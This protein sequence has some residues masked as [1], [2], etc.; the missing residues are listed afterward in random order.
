M[1][2]KQ[3]GIQSKALHWYPGHMAKTKRLIEENLKLID[4]VVEITD[5][6]IPYSGRNPYFNVMLRNKPRLIVM[7]KADMADKSVTDKW[8]SYFSEKGIKVIPISCLTGMG[9]NKI[10]SEAE[11]LVADKLKKDAENG[12]SRTLKLMMIGIPNVGKSSLIN[13]LSG[14]AGTI[15]GNKPG[16][17]KGKQWIRLK[18][19]SELLDTP[20]ILPQKFSDDIAPK[21]LAMTGAIKDEI[22]NTEL[23]SYDLIEYLKENY[24]SMLC[25]RYKISEDISGMEAYEILELI[26]KKR[27]FV[28]SGGETDTERA[29]KMLITELRDCKIGNIS[30]EKPEDI[31]G[32]N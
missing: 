18:G 32:G 11:S 4:V 10:I 16:V 3:T 8:I 27:G 13:K 30:L 25:E 21:K 12:R 1:D 31:F 9:V 20:G 19:K 14:K 17:T 2:T 24:H 29:A 22:I 7:N 5:A 15:T 28:I 26:G 23:L 6:R